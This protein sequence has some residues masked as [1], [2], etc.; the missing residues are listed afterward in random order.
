MG[1][2]GERIHAYQK[3]RTADALSV[4]L[5]R[6]AFWIAQ[7]LCLSTKKSYDSCLSFPNVFLP[8][9]PSLS[10]STTLTALFGLVWV[11]VSKYLGAWFAYL[12]VND[13]HE[14]PFSHLQESVW[15]KRIQVSDIAT[16]QQFDH[17][18][19]FGD[20]R[21]PDGGVVNGDAT[22]RRMNEDAGRL[23]SAERYVE[24]RRKTHQR[25]S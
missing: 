21:V 8:V 13:A 10:I 20:R 18:V 19:G 2:P 1:R 15:G 3:T 24:R 23:A 12:V 25:V 17:V 16:G 4:H 22:V 9:V 7:H 14:D 6:L 5:R 11:F